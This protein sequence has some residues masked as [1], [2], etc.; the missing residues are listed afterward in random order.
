MLLTGVGPIHSTVAMADLRCGEC[1][2]SRSSK[3]Q[4]RLCGEHCRQREYVGCSKDVRHQRGPKGRGCAKAS[5][6]KRQR[7]DAVRD[8]EAWLTKRIQDDTERASHLHS[9]LEK[10]SIRLTSIRTHDNLKD[11][12]RWDEL[13]ENFIGP[14][15]NREIQE[16]LLEDLRS[17]LPFNSARMFF[18]GSRSREASRLRS[19]KPRSVEAWRCR[20]ARRRGVEAWRTRLPNPFI[21]SRQSLL[22]SLSILVCQFKF[23]FP[24]SSMGLEADMFPGRLLCLW[25]ISLSLGLKY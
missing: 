17:S 3:C 16:N 5:P 2:K 25:P 7:Q 9:M 24:A 14:R 20:G 22:L 8:I 21:P 10:V 13:V 11:E 12:N 19:A 4:K 18:A 15:A 6:A 1:S 23:S